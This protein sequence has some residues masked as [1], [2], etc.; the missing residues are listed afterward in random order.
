MRP[1]GQPRHSKTGQTGPAQR[2]RQE[3]SPKRQPSE[4]SVPRLRPSDRAGTPAC[5]RATRLSY[6]SSDTGRNKSK[7][8]GSGSKAVPEL[9]F[10][11]RS[12]RQRQQLTARRSKPDRLSLNGAQAHERNYPA[13]ARRHGR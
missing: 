2:Q 3:W 6:K 5:E 12:H 1:R 7:E 10:G 13:R 11:P 8:N 4:F 9:P